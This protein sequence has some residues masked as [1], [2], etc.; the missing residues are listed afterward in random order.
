MH[1]SGSCL[2]FILLYFVSEGHGGSDGVHGYVSSLDH[3]VGDL[4][5]F[6]TYSICA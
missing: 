4:V 3:A 6:H 5:L 2:I 1:I